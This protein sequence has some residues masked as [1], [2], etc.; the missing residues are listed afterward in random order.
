MLIRDGNSNIT[1]TNPKGYIIVSGE[2]GVEEYDCAQCG[3]CQA[4]WQVIRG[5]GIKRGFCLQCKQ[6][7][8]GAD[9][10]M[11]HG[12][13]PFEKMFEAYE[14]RNALFKQLGLE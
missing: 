6:P 7:L 5:S 13:I 1:L 3:H 14:Q 12:C 8:C 9:P 11:N 10:C 2:N 4:Q